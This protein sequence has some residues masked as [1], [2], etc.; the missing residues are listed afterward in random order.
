MPYLILLILSVT[1][2]AVYDGRRERRSGMVLY[3][4]I[5]VLSALIA[6]LRY[7]L[8]VDTVMDEYMMRLEDV[9]HDNVD[10]GGIKYYYPVYI[11]LVR[12][13]RCFTYSIW[14]VQLVINLWIGFYVF[15][16]GYRMRHEMGGRL[17]LYVTLYLILWYIRLNFGVYRQGMSLGFFVLG[18][19]KLRERRYW[20]YIFFCLCATVCHRFGAVTILFALI[21][22]ARFKRLVSHRK[23]LIIILVSAFLTGMALRYMIT[24]VLVHIDF[25]WQRINND[26]A[27]YADFIIKNQRGL[28]GV[29]K[30]LILTVVYPALAMILLRR[31]NVWVMAAVIIMTAGIWLNP[32]DRLYIYFALI[33]IVEVVRCVAERR[34]VMKAWMW[35]ICFVPMM[36]M[37]CSNYVSVQRW[38]DGRDH[39]AYEYYWPYTSV[40]NPERNIAR[41]IYSIR[42][43]SC[44][45]YISVVILSDKVDRGEELTDEERDWIERL[46]IENRS[47][48]EGRECI[49]KD[50]MEYIRLRG[51]DNEESEW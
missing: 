10:V 20:W 23:S 49:E 13:M 16:F 43:F 45:H 27:A 44:D 35:V 29:I 5:G 21:E 46:Y 48:G 34:R 51:L 6:G 30:M 37:V 2:I 31:V 50:I 28:P 17:F 32:M 12:L 9:Y 14:P 22:S 26:I 24:D 42:R 39:R 7:R 1:G 18:W 47:A 36:V 11:G 19:L 25:G 4:L 40:L 8:G 38:P 41:E 3:I 33:C 15:Y